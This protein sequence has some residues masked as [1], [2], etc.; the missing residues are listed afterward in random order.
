[1]LPLDMMQHVSK[2]QGILVLQTSLWQQCITLF[3]GASTPLALSKASYNISDT[4]MCALDRIGLQ[5]AGARSSSKMKF[6]NA[7]R[8]SL[9][10]NA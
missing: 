7:E 2:D 3:D 1:M 10:Q 6:G 5:L 9:L 4:S 8:S